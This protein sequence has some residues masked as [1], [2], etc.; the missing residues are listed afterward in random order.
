MSLKILYIHL[1]T[2]TRHPLNMDSDHNYFGYMTWFVFG[3]W[4]LYFFLNL[5]EIPDIYTQ[6]NGLCNAHHFRIYFIQEN[7]ITSRINN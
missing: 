2:K 7:V 6:V 1:K 5:S 4:S 3:G